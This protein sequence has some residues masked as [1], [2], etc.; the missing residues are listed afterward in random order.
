MNGLKLLGHKSVPS[1]VMYVHFQ[2]Y[3]EHKCVP[4]MII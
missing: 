1:T 2:G 3:R 4:N